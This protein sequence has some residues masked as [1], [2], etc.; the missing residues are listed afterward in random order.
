MSVFAVTSCRLI[1]Q[2]DDTGGG[3]DDDDDGDKKVNYMC[4]YKPLCIVLYTVTGLS[5]EIQL[6]NVIQ[7]KYCQAEA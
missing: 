5:V 2:H 3:D 1:L 6:S 4:I 7:V